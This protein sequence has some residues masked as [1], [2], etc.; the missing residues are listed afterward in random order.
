VQASVQ[1]PEGESPGRKMTM[2]LS[3]LGVTLA[4]VGADFYFFWAA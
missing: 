3:V 2:I 1:T 4:Y